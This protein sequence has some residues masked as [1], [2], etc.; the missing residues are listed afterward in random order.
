MQET[1]VIRLDQ[2]AS[3]TPITAIPHNKALY[4]NMS[5]SY[6]TLVTDTHAAAQCGFKGQSGI[7]A[8]L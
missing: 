1:E 6:T 2:H 5:P 3:H 4:L 8:L 7:Y